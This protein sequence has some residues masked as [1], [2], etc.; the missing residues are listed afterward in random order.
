VLDN[1]A[2]MSPNELLY[3]AVISDR[4]AR[5]TSPDLGGFERRNVMLPSMLLV[6]HLGRN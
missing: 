4:M 1:A 6:G 2:P 3:L 5:P